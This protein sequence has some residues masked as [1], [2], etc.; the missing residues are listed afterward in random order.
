MFLI[1]LAREAILFLMKA[2]CVPPRGVNTERDKKYRIRIRT[3]STSK[4]SYKISKKT[5][6]RGR[7]G[8]KY[9][10]PMIQLEF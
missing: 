6:F 2:S 5:R 3:V 10:L 9:P 4:H 7:E 1:L 8:K